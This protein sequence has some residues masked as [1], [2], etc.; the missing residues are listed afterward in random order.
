MRNARNAHKKKWKLKTS[1]NLILGFLLMYLL[2]NF[3][4]GWGE[5][6]IMCDVAKYGT[7]EDAVTL[8]GYVFK[9]QS[10][11]Y[12][13]VGGTMEMAVANGARVRKGE[14]IASVYQGSISADIMEQLRNINEKIAQK[15]AN[16]YRKTIYASDA[17]AI[18]KQIGESSAG[19]SRRRTTARGTSCPPR[20][21]I[22]IT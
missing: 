13:P 4:Q 15:S 9:N 16:P 22:W 21:C 17:V 12:S 20:V 5:T 6:G 3:I 18:E 1:A 7:L 14:H 19:K 8:S 11:V 10:L 2:I